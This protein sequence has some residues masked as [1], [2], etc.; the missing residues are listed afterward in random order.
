MKIRHL[1]SLFS[2][3]FFFS[4]ILVSCRHTDYRR[5][6]GIVWNTT[7]HI[8]YQGEAVLRDSVLRVLDE[9][10]RCF[11]VFD[12]TSLVS[13]VNTSDSLEVSPIFIKVY[14]LSEKIC[15][16]SGGL[17]DPTLSPLISA[18]GFGPGHEFTPDTAAV[19]SVLE[20][21]GLHKTRLNRNYII[22]EDSRTQFNFSAA[23]KGFACDM[24]GEMFHRNGVLNYLVEIG[25][26]I[27]ASG[28]SPSGGKWKIS[29]DTPTVNPD[30]VTHDS[31]EVVQFTDAGMA[32]SG[33]YRNIK[34][35]ENGN[36]AHTISAVTGRPVQ[37]DVISAT[38]LAPT[39]AEADAAATACMASGSK[40]AIQM[41]NKLNL[42]GFL[43]LSDSTVVAT[44]DF[45]LAN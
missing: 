10:G 28:K 21:V 22:K 24:V 19:D 37:T 27:A 32:T 23:A 42:Q 41:L 33:N 45:P 36:V 44:N 39:C 31:F 13:R 29:I 17:F 11:N 14:R 9:V 20:F 12:T 40:A 26:E 5:E 43:I 34:H 2:A 8:T 16:A 6:E 7:Y 30:K 4:F 35:T 3:I 25:G 18:W 38:V 15:D 1:R